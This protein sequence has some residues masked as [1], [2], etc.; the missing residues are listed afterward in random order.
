MSIDWWTL[1][2]QAVNVILL[3]WMLGWFFWRPLAEMIQQRQAAAEALL[4][5]AEDQRHAAAAARQEIEKTRAGFTAERA[6]L[7]A[8]AQEV[9]ED[10]HAKRL[11]EA[12]DEAAAMMDATRASAEALRQ[13]SEKAWSQRANGLAIDIAGK[14][15]GRIDSAALGQAFLQQ[16]L[17]D[18]RAQPAALRQAAL[19]AGSTLLATTPRPLSPGEKAHHREAINDAFGGKVEIDFEVDAGLIAGIELSGP[20]LLVAN[21]WRA[22]L[23]RIE[24]EL[25]DDGSR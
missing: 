25:R 15:V 23:I 16:M 19:D 14:L 9:A 17:A 18:L 8:A 21:S 1:G 7:L 11:A 6:A 3:V 2:I 24:Q 4:S 5:D 12:A 10:A 13:R 20:H 22:D